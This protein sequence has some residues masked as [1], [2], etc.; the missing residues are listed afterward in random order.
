MPKTVERTVQIE[1]IEYNVA[2][3]VFSFKFL[4]EYHTK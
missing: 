4:I 2:G 1:I 3:V